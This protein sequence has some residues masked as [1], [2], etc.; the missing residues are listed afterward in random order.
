MRATRF[1][2]VLLTLSAAV[3]AR[4]ADDPA[5]TMGGLPT[6][7]VTRVVAD[8]IA[9]AIPRDYEKYKDWGNTKKITTGLD[10]HGHVW[11]PKIE[12]RKSEVNDGVW[13][14]YRLTLVEP[15]KNLAVRI[16]NLRSL[17]AGQAAFTLNIHAKV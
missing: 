13:K 4:A 17:D 10:F 12:R 14:H 7:A 3:G 5:P 16:D 6:D 15:E 2:A 9:D 1:A 11:D 8:M